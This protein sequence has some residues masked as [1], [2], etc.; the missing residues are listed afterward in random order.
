MYKISQYSNKILNTITDE[1]FLQDE[2]EILYPKY[3]TW[4]R[5]NGTPEIVDC[6][7]DEIKEIEFAKIAP[8]QK[9][10]LDKIKRYSLALAMG[11]SVNDDLE[12]FKEAYTTKYEMCKG[13]KIDPYDSILTESQLEGFVTKQEY[14]NIVIS[15]FEQGLMFRNIALQMSE[16]LRKLI[17][18]DITALNYTKA[19]ERLEI[20]NQLDSDITVE[21]V[22]GIFQQVLNL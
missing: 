15:K 18:N 2:R 6:F 5:A 11:K 13:T 22:S 17:L 21:D 8:L 12:Y 10:V 3:L 14:V 7:D 9:I 19:I 1:M 16:I 20:V 4:L